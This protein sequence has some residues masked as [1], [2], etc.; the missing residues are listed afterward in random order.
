MTDSTPLDDFHF[1]KTTLKNGLDV[2]VRRQAHLP[3]VAINLWYHVGSK[4][5]ERT[6]RGFTHLFEHLMF[7]GSQHYPG[8]FFKHLQRFGANI[9]G[10]TSSDRTNYYVDLPTAHAELAMAMESDRMANLLDALDDEKLRIQKGVVKN[11]YRQNYANRPYGMVWSLLAETLYPPHHPYSWLTIGVMEDIERATMEDVSAFFRR[12]YVPSNASLSIVGDLDESRAIALAERYFG[13]IAGGTP[14]LRPWAPAP[15]LTEDR[16]IVV[17]DRVELDRLYLIWPTVPHFHDDDAPL[18]LLADLLGRGRS[19]RLYRKLV[20]EEQIA[21]EVNVYQSGRELAGSFG[22]VVTI[23]PGRSIREARDL[24][25][26]ELVAMESSGAGE[27]ELERV[28]NLRVAGFCFALEH[29]GGFGG[30]ADRLNAYNVFRGDPGLIGSDVRRF[31]SVTLEE[32]RESARRYVTGRPCVALSVLGRKETDRGV[33]PLDRKAAPP[34]LEATGY[35]APTPQVLRL[36]CGL[37]LWVFPRRDLP[38]AAGSIVM[39]GG[40]G[41]Q[42]DLPGLAQLTADMLD[43]GTTIRTAAQI[44]MAAEAKGITIS[45]SCGWDGCYVG[46]KCLSHDLA[47]ALDL[48][49]DILINPT[50]PEAEWRRVHGQTLAAL[51]AERDNAEARAYRALLQALY[52]AGH[53]YR[54]PLG[55]T[56]DSVRSISVDDSR[57]FHASAMVPG[58]AAIVVAGDVDVE[59]LADELDRRLAHW[60][61]PEITLPRIPDVE[62]SARP[63]I[64]LLDRPG[65]PQAVV[66]AGHRGIDRLHPAF[67]HMLMFNQILGGQFTSRLNAKLREERAVTY[68]VRSQFEC[69]RSAGPFS[70][71]TS[72]QSD[73]IGQALED[74]RHELAAFVTGR[75]PTQEELDD[76]RRALVEGQPRHFETPSALVNRFASLLIHQLPADHEA[77]FTDRLMKIDRESLI[78]SARSLIHPDALVAVVVADAAQVLESLKQLDWADPEL[79][80]G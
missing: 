26:A 53:P 52:G 11:E 68:G 65:A 59:T 58:R 20:L 13:T 24:I 55:G 71:G 29:M 64:L 74:I 38:T 19:S 35:E 46:F 54:F 23:R 78:Q 45:A 30:V 48:S 75:P 1:T 76:A 17:H 4:N 7:E 72:V 21:Q 8:D 79:I 47:T 51:R 10:S 32:I 27:D 15:S 22:I 34:R 31:Q 60:R 28:Q 69:R 25:Q 44:A 49:A 61:G 67:D 42:P 9:N 33:P 14:A 41:L 37:Q 16:E 62:L 43:E 3:I 36:R 57:A 39:A 66:R 5:E 70:I 73:R 56:E 18:L 50:F 80:E 2:I 12:Y 6:Q 63:R 77:G 40:A